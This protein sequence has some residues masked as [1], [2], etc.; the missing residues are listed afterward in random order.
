M[1]FGPE[2]SAT[3]FSPIAPNAS[4]L[5]YEVRASLG[6]KI[7]VFVLLALTLAAAVLGAAAVARQPATLATGA[8]L[9]FVVLLLAMAA[10]CGLV[11]WLGRGPALVLYPDRVEKR[12]LWGVRSLSR[13]EIEGVTKVHQSRNGAWFEIV[14]KPGAGDGMH[15]DAAMRGD[16]VVEAWLSGAPDPATHAKARDH[17]QVLADLRYGGSA[18]ERERR[19]KQ[20]RL[21][22]IVFSAVCTLLALWLGL[23]ASL[24]PS[25]L[26]FAVLT[27]ATALAMAAGSR[28]LIVWDGRARARPGVVLGLLPALAVSVKA[29]VSV[30]ML[31]VGPLIWGGVGL[32][33]AVAAF[34]AQ[35][36]SR[37]GMRLSHAALAGL[38]GGLIAYGGGVAL[39][40][41]LDAARPQSFTT[42][43]TG[44][45]VLRGRS[46]TYRLHLAPWGPDGAQRADVSRSFY[47]GV[48]V[49]AAICPARH[50]GALGLA[51]YQLAPC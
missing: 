43:V 11:V 20:A 8:A 12:E 44:M 37:H 7:S 50:P 27:A 10:V 31:T 24:D 45:E 26:A 35:Q 5:P 36:P 33:V 1:D 32:G 9:L 49:G 16:P 42:T 14:A 30:H 28:G 39:D 23:F 21:L 51:W 41:G 3:A 22:A 4:Q 34:V 25:A 6:S 19:L 46:N 47:A 15:L 13:R 29:L 38:L 17:A 48:T 2:P 18:E 40:V